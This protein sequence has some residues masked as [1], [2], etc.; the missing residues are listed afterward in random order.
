MNQNIMIVNNTGFIIDDFRKVFIDCVKN[1]K[2]LPEE[3][4][5]IFTLNRIEVDGQ[6][7]GIVNFV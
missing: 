3:I 7:R 2:E 4:S 6:K 5:D 1:D